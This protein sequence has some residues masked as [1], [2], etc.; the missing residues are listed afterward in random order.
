MEAAC[1][2][3]DSAEAQWREAKDPAPPA[4]RLGRAQAKL[5]RA[6]AAQGD[7]RKAILDL[8]KAHKIK[9]AELQARLDEDTEKVR[10]RRAQLAEV[11]GELAN[12]GDGARAR[13]RQG[14][15]VQKVHATLS[16]TVAPTIS[17]L[18]EQLDS[19][20]PAWAMLNGLLGT[21]SSSQ[22]LLEEA[23]A[24]PHPAQRFDI[25][26]DGGDARDDGTDWR[27]DDDS[28]TEW[29]ESHE[30]RDGGAPRARAGDHEM[31]CD[32]GAPGDADGGDGGYGSDYAMGDRQWWGVSHTEWQQGVRWESCGHGKWS[33]N[34]SSWADSWEE[35][36]QRDDGEAA[37]PA[38]ARR[39]L[40]PSPTPCAPSGGHGGATAADTGVGADDTRRQQQ[41]RGERLQHIIE[42]AIAAGVQPVTSAGE[43]LHV[44]D[45]DQ[46]AAWAAENLPD[47][48]TR[49]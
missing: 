40:E 49:R 2:A 15:A 11:Q 31:Q 19:S 7:T 32:E 28:D 16:G 3:R 42:A 35:E 46:L 48:G 36:R 4:V 29:S 41:Q 25:G 6:V 22:T 27:H 5:D 20:T 24:P 26:D 23:I 47:G 38:A 14:R 30:L 17:A 13:A 21:L 1:A 43:D 39:R 33:K 45:A 34:C 37:Q 8:E 18:V 9:M 10:L 44:L 12:V